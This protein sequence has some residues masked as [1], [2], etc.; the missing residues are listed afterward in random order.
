MSKVDSILYKLK[1]DLEKISLGSYLK[2]RKDDM[3]ALLEEY[4]ENQVSYF[5][6][7]N[8]HRELDEAKK[9]IEKQKSCDLVIEKLT[10]DRKFYMEQVKTQEQLVDDI[11]ERLFEKLKKYHKIFE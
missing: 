5:A 3:E 7:E 1:K 10:A 11:V 8:L 6:Y 4:E 2:I 9:T